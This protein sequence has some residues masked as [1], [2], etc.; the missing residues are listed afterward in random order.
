LF[1][2]EENLGTKQPQDVEAFTTNKSYAEYRAEQN[3][4]Q[5]YPTILN[6]QESKLLDKKETRTLSLDRD[7]FQYQDYGF[8]DNKDQTK[9]LGNFY[10]VKENNRH[11]LGSKQDIEGFKEFV[12]GKP[13]DKELTQIL[14]DAFLTKQDLEQSTNINFQGY[15]GGFENIGKGTKEGD[16]KDKAM[17]KVADGFIGELGTQKSSSTLTSASTI[18]KI[19]QKDILDSIIFTK[20]KVAV[21]PSSLNDNAK[22]IM[23]ARNK[24]GRENEP[25][26]DEVKIAI[27]EARNKGAEFVVGDMPNVDSQF[28][29]YLQ[30]IGAKFT[31]YHTGNTSRIEVQQPIKAKP[32]DID[33]LLG[34]SQYDVNTETVEEIPEELDEQAVEEIDETFVSDTKNEIIYEATPNLVIGSANYKYVENNQEYTYDSRT[35]LTPLEK[36]QLAASASVYFVRSL[37]K[38][39]FDV[40]KDS[41]P[42]NILREV[43]QEVAADLVKLLKDG[44]KNPVIIAGGPK[45]E[46]AIEVAYALASNND[47]RLESVINIMSNMLNVNYKIN[48]N[49]DEG[50]ILETT[51]QEDEST[52]EESKEEAEDEV[53]V[54]KDK[55]FDKNSTEFDTKDGLPKIVKL[56]LGSLLSRNSSKKLI[57]NDFGLPVPESS[58]KVT[59]FIVN[60]FAKKAGNVV[61]LFKH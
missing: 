10:I 11:I 9:Q 60:N 35:E 31:I 46:R 61:I 48:L 55:A 17:R 49:I 5:V 43:L 53:D 25:L 15:K 13:F 4:T 7:E 12:Q 27:L 45:A 34:A 51:E 38:K 1:T 54:Q 36:E 59:N 44:E 41:I 39:E 20:S 18:L 33:S 56:I 47:N 3:N 23:L 28:I 26:S 42:T 57:R 58:S 24:S 14:T 32:A 6:I 30:E 52:T 22:V 19:P 29:D 40:T 16:G 37:L 8:T 50:V 21:A 2:E